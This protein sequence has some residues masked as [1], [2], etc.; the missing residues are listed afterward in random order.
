MNTG[1]IDFHCCIVFQCVYHSMSIVL[2]TE[3]WLVSSLER[4]QTML[5]WA[6]LHVYWGVPRWWL[7]VKNPLASAGDKRDAGSIPGWGRSLGGMQDNPL[8]YSCLE[9]PMDRG[10][11]WAIVH[12]VTKSQTRLK[13]LSMHACKEQENKQIYKMS[14][15][16]RPL[17]KFGGSYLLVFIL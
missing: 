13:W 15:S 1:F 17:S 6:Y 7:V 10:G 11:W 8:Q 2:F 12:G 9:N 3:I 16:K 5:L 14:T 4:L